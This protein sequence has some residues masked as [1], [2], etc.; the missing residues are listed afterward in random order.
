[1]KVAITG[2][3]GF[4][5]WHTRVLIRA[6]GWPEPALLDRATLAEPAV[7]ADRLC[8]VDRVL[9][10]AGVNRGEPA[11]VAAGNVAAAEALVRGLRRCAQPPKTLVYANSTQ[12]GNGTPYGDSKARAAGILAD[13]AI[14]CQFVDHRLPHLY[15]EH[16]RPFYN[17]VT[18][19]FCRLIADG[20]QPE[21]REDRELQLVHATDAAAAMLDAPPT[22]SW[23]AS[24]PVLRIGVQALA[25]R[26]LS[27]A[28]SYRDAEIPPL[29]DRH[30]VRLFNS[31][32]SHLF[33]ARY[34]MPLVRRID[35]RGELVETVKARGGAGQT[36]CSTTHAGATRGEHFHLAKVERFVVFRGR[37]E[38]RLRR[39]GHHQVIRFSVDGI[40]PVV[41]DM[42]TMW[43][44]AIT[45]T[46]PGELVTLFWTNDLFDPYRPDTYAEPVAEVA[47][48]AV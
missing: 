28:A 7:L 19:T 2:G 20:G 46:G 3:G 45:N 10:L 24:M 6:L 4:L 25:D 22:G 18:A 38:I 16:G 17:S 30:E 12:A 26:L 44:H 33:P 9:H 43:A 29:P 37:A 15:G 1:M 11:E 36:F 42:P 41:V 32:R 31:Y 5:G 47:A 35:Q 8:G 14:G 21:V 34:P 23:D 48:A 13:A 39:V 40:E 27:L